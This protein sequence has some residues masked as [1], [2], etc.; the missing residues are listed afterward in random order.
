MANLAA[1]NARR[2][3]ALMRLANLRRQARDEIDRLIRFLDESDIDP[4]LEETGD[5]EPSIGVSYDAEADLELD[6]CDTEDGGD[7]E[8]SLGWTV[9]GEL[10]GRSDRELCHAEG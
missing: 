3:K 2:R 7:G 9:D 1:Q 6:D 8:P 5:D 4:D 10:G